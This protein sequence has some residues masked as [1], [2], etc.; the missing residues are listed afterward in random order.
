MPFKEAGPCHRAID[1]I[2]KAVE[3]RR[4]EL[5]LTDTQL[6]EAAGVSPSSLPYWRKGRSSPSLANVRAITQA[7]GL[8]LAIV[9]INQPIEGEIEPCNN[10]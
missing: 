4:R 5:G 1:P 10:S 2:I 6:A 9:P 8:R 3:E 7:A